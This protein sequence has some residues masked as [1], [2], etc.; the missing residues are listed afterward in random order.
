MSQPLAITLAPSAT[1]TGGGAGA[2][3]DVGTTRRTVALS[4]LVTGFVPVDS[5]PV[6]TL[7]VVVET[8]SGVSAP[9]RNVDA[10]H[11]TAAGAYALA[12][13]ALDQLVRV[14]WVLV[15]LT[16]VT[17]EVAG[18]AHLTYVDP[19]DITRAIPAHSIEE[20]PASDR[21]QA[22][23]DV[24]S[25]AD[26]YLNS[27][28]QLPIKAWGESLRKKCALLAAAQIFRARGADPAGPD[29][30]VFDAEADAIRWFERVADGKLKPPEI[31]DDTPA[32]F[33]GG[34]VVV[35]S[36]RRRSTRDEWL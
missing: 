9:W 1:V 22:C 34:G 13:G 33:E 35:A 27:S 17:F 4:L 10:L 29:K 23:I 18:L 2:S 20:I 21:A 7:N 6:P 11:V 28:F 3:V 26:A 31:V 30:M 5:D 15:N 14:S 19:A 25:D 24:T 32:V 36:G 8:R 12:V 16:S